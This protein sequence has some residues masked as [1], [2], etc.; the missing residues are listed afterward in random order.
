MEEDRKTVEPNSNSKIP[1]EPSRHPPRV[2]AFVD[3]APPIVGALMV[4]FT[5]T[6]PQLSTDSTLFVEASKDLDLKLPSK[7]PSEKS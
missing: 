1:F 2:V 3:N 4:S 5:I 7:R 6:T